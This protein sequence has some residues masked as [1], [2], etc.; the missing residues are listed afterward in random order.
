MIEHVA[1]EMINR[2]FGHAPSSW[3]PQVSVN[4]PLPRAGDET[5]VAAP[6]RALSDKATK[7]AG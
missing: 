3:H 6:A 7:P 2:A 4:V 5:A 1:C